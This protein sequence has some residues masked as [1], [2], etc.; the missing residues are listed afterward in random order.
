[1]ER[2]WENREVLPASHRAPASPVIRPHRP[3]ER[4]G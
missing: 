2:V 3:L 1:V 4:T